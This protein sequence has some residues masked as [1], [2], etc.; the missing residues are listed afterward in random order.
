MKLYIYDHC[1]F[2]V[3]ARMIF[4]LKQIPVTE[5]ILLN[6]DMETPTRMVGRKLV[7]ILEHHG[8]FMPESMDI[9]THIDTMDGKPVLTG[10]TRPEISRWLATEQPAYI[11]LILPRF[12][13][14]PLPEFA[15]TAARLYFIRNKEEMVGPF[16]QRLAESDRLRASTNAGLARLAGLI[17]SPA[18]VNGTLSTDDIHLFAHLR[19]LTIVAGL[20]WPPAVRAYCQHM[21]QATGIPLL[22]GMAG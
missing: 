14:S 11:D 5:I 17:E 6:D 12:A 15:T 20:D 19:S 9:V 21:S 3:K 10:P 13:A 8:Q 4:G 22:D 2:C 1:P 16:A 18:A 7:P